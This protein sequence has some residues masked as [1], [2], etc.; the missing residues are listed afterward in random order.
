MNVLRKIVRLAAWFL[1]AVVLVSIVFVAHV[2]RQGF[3]SDIQKADTIIVLGA[4]QWNNEPSPM[5]QARLH[6][7]RELYRQGYATSIIVTGGRAPG[8]AASDSSIGKTYLARLGIPAN[9]IYIE[10]WSRTTLQNLIFAHE[11][12]EAQSF[13]SALLISHDFHIMRAGRMAH[14]LGAIAFPA[15]V[16]TEN[17]V[18]KLRYAMRE[19]FLYPAYLLLH[20]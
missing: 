2:Y 13:R 11:I 20:I 4:A 12:M 6:R 15:P 16:Q 10:E 19:L 14:D 9:R 18:I 5:F 8:A 7:A 17:P 1:G 3:R